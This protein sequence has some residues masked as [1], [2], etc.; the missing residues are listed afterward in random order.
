[1]GLQ[2]PEAFLQLAAEGKE[3]FRGRDCSFQLYL[4]SHVSVLEA[5]Q[6]CELRVKQSEAPQPACPRLVGPRAE[7]GTPSQLC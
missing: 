3:G 6:S 7:P 5:T 2:S 4:N 1:M